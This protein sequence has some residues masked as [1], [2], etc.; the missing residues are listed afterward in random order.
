MSTV[1]LFGNLLADFSEKLALLETIVDQ[2]IERIR[3]D[4]DE[5]VHKMHNHY[6]EA[7]AR[8]SRLQTAIRSFKGT[9]GE[10]AP[11][12]DEMETMLRSPRT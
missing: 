12:L 9:E 2:E 7:T 8:L 3:Q 11:T 5:V 4:H 10:R 1:M 6:N